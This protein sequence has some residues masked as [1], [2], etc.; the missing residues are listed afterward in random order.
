[1]ANLEYLLW[2]YFIFYPV[3][4]YFTHEK[5]KQRINTQP[6]LKL[7]LYRTTMLHIWLPTIL[8]LAM[9]A[10]NAL[11]PSDIG[12]TWQ[13]LWPNTLGIALAIMIVAYF[14]FAFVQLN[15]SSDA[16]QTLSKQM[17]HVGWFMP[18]T[19]KESR[20]FI[21]G[22]A[23]SAGICEELL[24]RGFLLHSL[25]QS[26]P[27]Y[28]AVIISSVAFGLGHIYQGWGNVVKTSVIGAVMALIFLLTDSIIVPILLHVIVDMFGGIMG[29]KVYSGQPSI[30]TE[31]RQIG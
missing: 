8:V 6:H 23:I 13:W 31:N 21:F 20:Y 2:A 10:G 17:A 7:A 14:I 19:K 27:I 15:N 3:Y 12:L 25:G 24:F 29:Y 22:V 1:M 9:L 26:L 16:R 4:G 11:S 28:A 5:D 18:T 30:N